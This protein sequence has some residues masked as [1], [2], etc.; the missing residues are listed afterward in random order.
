MNGQIDPSLVVVL[1]GLWSKLCG[2]SSRIAIMLIC[3]QCS[4]KRHIG[5]LMPPLE[6]VV[7]RKWFFFNAQNKP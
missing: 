4:K 2:Q 7:V 6:E 1:V 5:C 3:D